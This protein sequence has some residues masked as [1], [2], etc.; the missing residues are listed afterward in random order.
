MD[1]VILERVSKRF[2]SLTAVGD[3]SLRVK[4]GALDGYIV[5]PN[6]RSKDKPRNSTPLIPAI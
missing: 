3:L 5:V 6:T 4:Q 2:D 1:A